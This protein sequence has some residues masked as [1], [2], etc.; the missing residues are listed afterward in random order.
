MIDGILALVV[1][2]VIDGDTFIARDAAGYEHR[3]SLWGLDAPELSERGG[4][5]ARALLTRLIDNSDG[6][7]TCYVIDEDRYGRTVARCDDDMPIDLACMM[8]QSGAATEWFYFSQGYY[9]KRG[10][11]HEE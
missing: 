3:I 11:I 9:R 2:F 7:V 5:Q 8:I 10:C 6:R 4:P 1:A